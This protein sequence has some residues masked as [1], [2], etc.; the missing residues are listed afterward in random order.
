MELFCGDW[1]L[2][3]KSAESMFCVV[4]TSASGKDQRLLERDVQLLVHG[5]DAFAR[6]FKVDYV[7]K[8]G[9]EP[10][11]TVVPAIVTNAELFVAGYKTGDVSLESGQ[12]PM[13]LPAPL[14]PAPW[15]RFR[16]AFS[17]NKDLGDRTV[18]LVRASEFSRWLQKLEFAGTDAVS[19]AGKAHFE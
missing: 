17:G 1:K 12:L 8:G 16:K 18:F 14:Q 4:S 13:P 9:N 5:T 15:V 7:K 10:D 6:Q 2:I 3:P 11:H 19:E